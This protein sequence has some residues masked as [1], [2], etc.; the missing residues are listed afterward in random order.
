VTTA[1]LY[2]E[3]AA[4]SS[5]T[6]RTLAVSLAVHA[7]LFAW[8][9]LQRT[10]AP[11]LPGIVEVSWLESEPEP[12]I[13]A[14]A[15]PPAPRTTPAP[16][17]AEA[18][19]SPSPVEEKF[20]RPR[21][22]APVE[23]TPQERTANRDRVRERVAALAPRSLPVGELTKGTVASRSLLR[24]APAAAAPVVSGSPA[25]DLTRAGTRATAPAELRREAQTVGR[26]RP[27]LATAP[28]ARSAPASAMPDLAST[29]RRSLEGAELTGEIADRPVLEHPMPVYPEWA[30]TQAVEAA[31]TLTFF[32]LPDGTVRENVQVSRT[33]GFTDFDESAL[34]AL[35]GWRFAPL[36]GAAAAVQWGTITFRFRLRD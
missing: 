11:E 12:E 3:L 35:A 20:E 24:A 33:A 27:D 14:M 10:L 8:L 34:R 26:G 29:A 15:P 4:G 25:L 23:P 2:H 28:R 9:A 16:E 13:V 19:R 7:A 1:V 21:Q 17:K 36:Q 32:V 6:R 22:E 18:P 30:K 5:R 31:V